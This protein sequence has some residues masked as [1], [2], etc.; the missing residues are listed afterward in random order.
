MATTGSFK[1]FIDSR[2]VGRQPLGHF[3]LPPCFFALV[4]RR[5]PNVWEHASPTQ[6]RYEHCNDNHDG[7]DGDS[8]PDICDMK[9]LV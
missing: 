4:V 1:Q 5:A 9:Y 2:K 7:D 8:L 3:P 6:T